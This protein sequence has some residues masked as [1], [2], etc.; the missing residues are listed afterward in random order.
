[1]PKAYIFSIGEPTVELTDWSLKR[2][3]FE[4]V[5]VHNPDT[6]LWTKLKWLYNHETEDFIRVDGDIIV[7]RNILKLEPQDNCWWHCGLGW[8]WLKQDL[9]PISIHWVKKEALPYLKKNIDKFENAERPETE[10]FRIEEFINPRRCEVYNLICG[11]HG[12]GQK[13]F[14]RAKG[15]KDRR[16][17]SEDYDFELAEKLS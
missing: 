17:Q 8:D 13:E 11:L 12:W 10:I 7:N 9:N 3:G 16:G 15:N 14:E 5:R 4:T 1:M 2:L 6:S